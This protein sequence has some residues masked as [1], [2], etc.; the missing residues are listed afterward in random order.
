VSDI[1][2]ALSIC[3]CICEKGTTCTI[4]ECIFPSRHQPSKLNAGGL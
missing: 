2:A 1:S 4:S 3:D